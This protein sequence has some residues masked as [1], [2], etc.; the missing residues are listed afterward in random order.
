[1]PGSQAT[2]WNL[3]RAVYSSRTLVGSKSI[4]PKL[5]TARPKGTANGGSGFEAQP[6]TAWY[7]R[8]RQ[9]TS[10]QVGTLIFAQEISLSFDATIRLR[11]FS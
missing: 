10:P 7:A 5:S 1:M 6:M 2:S 3:R 9:N 11:T 8:P 4:A